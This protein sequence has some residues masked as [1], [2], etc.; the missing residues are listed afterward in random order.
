MLTDARGRLRYALAASV[1]VLTTAVTGQALGVLQPLG[2]GSA[3][4]GGAQAARPA[5]GVQPGAR[6]RE[7]VALGD[8][9]TSGPL[10]PQM[11]TDPL[12]CARSTRNYPSILAER[13]GVRT[14][15]DASCGGAGTEHLTAPQR[16]AEGTNPPQADAL[17]GRTDLV[18]LSIG[19]NDEGVLAGLIETCQ[20]VRERDATGAPCEAEFS[21]AGLDEIEP[22]ID[23]TAERVRLALR[24]IHRRAP[25]AEVLVIGYPRLVPAEGYC[26][27]LLP[28]AYRDYAY[29]DGVQQELNAA[30]SDATEAAGATY[31]DTY[32]PSRGHDVCAGDAAWVNGEDTQPFAALA[33]HPFVAAMDAVAGIVQRALGATTARTLPPLPEPP[34]ADPAAV[35]RLARLLDGSTD[36]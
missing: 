5:A 31:V 22:R 6:Y 17:S 14:F 24:E 10:I 27:R 8:S 2:A 25:G 35:R 19:G 13:L 1:I 3:V 28:F 32:G 4:P 36:P 9:F 18:T 33:F 30:L 11:R 12:G 16:T 7:Y 20:R 29:V 34:V 26:P 15:T 21:G 23:R